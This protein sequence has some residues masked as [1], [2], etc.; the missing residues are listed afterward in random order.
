MTIDPRYKSLN[1]TSVVE[2]AHYKFQLG[3]YFSEK[4]EIDRAELYFSRRIQDSYWN[5][6]TKVNIS[7]KTIS[8]FLKEIEKYY[9]AKKRSPAVYVTPTSRPSNLEDLLIANG[10]RL[11]F[12]DA[13]LVYRGGDI[14]QPALPEDLNVKLVGTFDEMKEFVKVFNLAY[15]SQ[16]G[17]SYAGIPP[18][19]GQSLLASYHKRRADININHYLATINEEPVGCATIIHNNRIGG[20]YNLGV[21]PKFQNRRIGPI[22]AAKRIV[23]AKKRGLRVFFLQTEEG[24]AVESF[25]SKYLNFKKEFIG[26][27]YNKM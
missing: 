14:R 7:S 26:K 8:K 18:S 5:Y 25:C 27:C 9:T 2:E 13:W 4:K 19:Y 10:Y 23:D 16:A 6:A 20:L 3:L 24:T 22:L 12:T 1:R 11:Q 21:S 17:G 15:G